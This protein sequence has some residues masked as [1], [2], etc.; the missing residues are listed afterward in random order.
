[1]LLWRFFPK[2]REIKINFKDPVENTS[3]LYKHLLYPNNSKTT[4]TSQQKT[5]GK[6]QRTNDSP[7]FVFIAITRMFTNP[8]RP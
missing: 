2:G 4:Q 1:M 8:A 3:I 5:H 6:T 7:I